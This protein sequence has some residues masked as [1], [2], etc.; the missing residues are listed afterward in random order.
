VQ[1]ST[2]D[3]HLAVADHH[4]WWEGRRRI[5]AAEL[6]RLRLP[7]GAKILEIGCGSGSTIP[8]L[9]RYGAVWATDPDV[10]MLAEAACRGAEEVL[11]GRLPDDLPFAG[12]QFDLIA[13]LDV[14]EHLDDDSGALRHVRERL[15]ADGRLFLAVPAYAWLWS[16]QDDISHHKRRYTLPRLVAACH[17]AGLVVERATYFNTL[18][19][20]MAVAARLTEKLR[21][22]GKTPLGLSL[23]PPWQ[24]AVLAAL[25]G[26]ERHLLARCSL[27]FGL[28]AMAICR[29]R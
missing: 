10:G 18:L 4:W 15:T 14:L 24:N 20:P 5:L 13:M 23:P 6:D 11:P 12:R 28:S 2:Y 17:V 25:F 7:G 29:Q 22:P 3:L 1:P 27:P 21:G 8:L 9:A 16:R 19:F 26:S